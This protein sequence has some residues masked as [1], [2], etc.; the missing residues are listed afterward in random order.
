MSDVLYIRA[1]YL[2]RYITASICHSLPILYP[3]I[4][5]IVLFY[6][7]MHQDTDRSH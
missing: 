2:G 4:D 7:T 6:A 5:N 1:H 3:R